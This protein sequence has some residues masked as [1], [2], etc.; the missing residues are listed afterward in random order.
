VA[1]AAEGP[2]KL[3]E[4]KLNVDAA[5]IRTG[6]V[7]A[8]QTCEITGIGPVPATTARALLNDALVSVVV[9]D[10]GD[11]TAVTKATRTIPARLRR[12]VEARY[13]T[14]GRRSCAND[15]FLQIDHVIPL[16]AHG[17]TEFDNLWRLCPHCHHLKTHRGWRVAGTPH[18]WDLV[19]PDNP[20][21]GRAPP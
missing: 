16:E 18:D 10:G 9:K 5:V 4:V 20:K 19:P 3:V 1:L 8:G 21:G 2:C 13:P 15:Q 7:E 11:I 14:C 17:R 12:A 6:H